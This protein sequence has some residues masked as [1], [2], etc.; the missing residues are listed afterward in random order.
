VTLQEAETYFAPQIA[1]LKRMIA[2]GTPWVFL[3]GSA[4]IDYLSKLAAGK[5]GYGEGFKQ[6][7]TDYMPVAYRTFK[8][9]SGATDL[10]EQLYHVLRCGIVHSFSLIPDKQARRKGGRDRS[11][12]L[13]HDGPHLSAYSSTN[14]PD[15]C[16]L[17]ADGFVA[18]LEA[19]MN[20]LFADASTNT[21]L[22]KN[23]TAWLA[24]HPPIAGNI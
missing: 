21:L 9:Q 15:A 1:D 3:C 6:F 13:S 4:V 10:P 8:Y 14:A 20:K 12:V 16:R 2:D 5:N 23:I 22:A 17:R 11:V 18:D 19:A 7:V 24:L